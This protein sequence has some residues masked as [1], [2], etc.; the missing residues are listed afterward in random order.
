MFNDFNA[1]LPEAAT[2]DSSGFQEVIAGVKSSEISFDGLGAYDDMSTI[3]LA[4]YLIAEL[5]LL[6]FGTAA[7]GD[8]VYT[9]EGFLSCWNELEMES[10][11][12]YSGSITTTDLIASQRT[13]GVKFLK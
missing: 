6:R 11:V 7:S 13:H 12:T 8:D 3:E 2:K 4:D 1:D 9:V 10:H 5:S